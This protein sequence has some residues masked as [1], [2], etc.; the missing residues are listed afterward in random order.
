MLFKA[1]VKD[2]ETGESKFV[3]SDYPSKSDFVTDLKHNGYSVSRAEPKDL[4]DFILN[5]FNGDKHEWEIAKKLYKEGKPL[6]KEEY[7][8]M[9]DGGYEI[10]N[11]KF[12]DAIKDNFTPPGAK[13]NEDVKV[14]EVDTSAIDEKDSGKSEED[15]LDLYMKDLDD[16]M[17]KNKKGRDDIPVTI[18]R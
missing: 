12:I 5:N 2:K 8:K 14:E 7:E 15:D 9:K 11:D 13:D 4:Y 10:V 3:E 1:F 17:T 18:R 16:Y 6:T